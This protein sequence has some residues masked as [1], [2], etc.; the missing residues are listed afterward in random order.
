M[1]LAQELRPIMH[2]A[3]PGRG[4]THRADANTAEAKDARKAT[5]TNGCNF[6]KVSLA[7]QGITTL[8][9]TCGHATYETNFV[10][11]HP[12]HGF[13]VNRRSRMHRSPHGGQAHIPNEMGRLPFW[14]S[15][16][17]EAGYANAKT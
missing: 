11:K 8:F 7:A 6:P 3:V 12:P 5:S 10:A 15:S 2:T 16:R 13:R 9:G 1:R 4:P 14:T 17:D